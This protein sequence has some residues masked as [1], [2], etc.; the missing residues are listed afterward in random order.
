MQLTGVPCWAC[1]GAGRMASVE[2]PASVRRLHIFADND[3]PGVDAADATAD[4]YSHLE[5]IIRRPKGSFSDFADV[6]A[7][8][9]KRGDAA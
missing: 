1:L 5:I 6:S 4:T 7:D 8:H 9:A 3:K 2:I